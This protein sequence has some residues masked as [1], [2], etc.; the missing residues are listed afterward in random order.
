MEDSISL[1]P[2][3]RILRK[4]NKVTYLVYNFI[5]SQD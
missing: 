1:K 4:L 5:P 3:N 2:P